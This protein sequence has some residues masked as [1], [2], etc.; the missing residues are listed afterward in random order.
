MT[1]HPIAAIAES[2][3]VSRPNPSLPNRTGGVRNDSLLHIVLLSI[4]SGVLVA[5]WILQANPTTVTLPVLDQPLPELCL[6]RRLTG[7]SCPGCGLTRCFISLAHGDLAA[8]W[9]FNPAGIWL[10]G[11]V[12]AQVPLRGYQLWRISRGRGELVLIGIGQAVLVVFVVAL[13]GQWLLRLAG[14]QF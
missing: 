9:S 5:A 6:L 13:L 8:A 14:L 11:I 10:F 12:A 2:S 7:F 3:V 4:S 1:Q